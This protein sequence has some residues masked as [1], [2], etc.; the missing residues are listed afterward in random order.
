[1]WELGQHLPL[2]NHS[3]VITVLENVPGISELHRMTDEQRLLMGGWEEQL[4][5]ASNSENSLS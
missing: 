1:M 4:A 3:F 5:L 2:P